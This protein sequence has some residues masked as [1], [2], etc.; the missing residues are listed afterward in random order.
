VLF[1]GTSTQ[2]Q[3]TFARE[4][5]NGMVKAMVLVGPRG[6]QYR[7]DDQA[8]SIRW[9]VYD[10]LGS[11]VGEVAPDGTLTRTQAFD[12][13]GCVRTSSG[14]ATTKHK[15]VGSLGHPSDDETG[16]I[17]MRARHYDPVVGR[18]V[19]EDPAKH[20]ADW[21]VYA[22]SNPVCRV[23]RS[24][25]EDSAAEVTVTAEG[26]MILDGIGLDLSETTITATFSGNGQICTLFIHYLQALGGS[27]YN[28]FRLKNALQMWALGNNVRIIEILGHGMTGGGEAFMNAMN[29]LVADGA[30]V[31]AL[32]NGITQLYW[33]LAI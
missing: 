5:L 29:I 23:D 16:L 27:G 4:L 18:F 19:S 33:I 11:V 25:R 17:Y 1:V 10:G 7:R 3:S 14:A 32:D 2:D 8:G 22:R 21:F 12:V 26:E 30:G 13:Y 31:T 6:P 20:G 9:Y 24:G 15:F 28:V